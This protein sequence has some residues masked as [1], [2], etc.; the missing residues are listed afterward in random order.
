MTEANKLAK[1]IEEISK[2]TVLEVADLVKALEE[3]F[4]VSASTMISQAA[5][6]TSPATGAAEP[7]AEQTSFT[8]VLTS[9]GAN[10]IGAIKAIKEINQAL[11][12]KEAKG[13]VEAAP[14]EILTGVNKETAEEAKKKLEAVGATVEIK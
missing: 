5:A 6:P 7:A 14:K 9:G 13:L 1:L 4:G 2:L 8:V 10:K 11:G 12:L 3:K